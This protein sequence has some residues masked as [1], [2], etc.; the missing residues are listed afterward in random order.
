MAKTVAKAKEEAEERCIVVCFVFAAAAF[1][2]GCCNCSCCFQLKKWLAVILMWIFVIKIIDCGFGR[3]Y[4]KR[5]E[6]SKVEELEVII[7]SVG[8]KN[9]S[10]RCWEVFPCMNCF[11]SQEAANSSDQ[12][13]AGHGV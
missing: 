7:R 5:K 10:C 2:F 4:K 11:A 9:D 3:A 1:Y 13:S 6:L 8:K 12:T